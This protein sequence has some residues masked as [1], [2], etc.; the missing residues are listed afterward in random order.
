[1]S[2]QHRTTDTDRQDAYPTTE[3]TE[4]FMN[5]TFA[6]TLLAG[7]VLCSPVFAQN[8]LRPGRLPDGPA[9]AIGSD[10]ETRPTETKPAAPAKAAPTKPSNTDNAK[11]ARL[12]LHQA[13]QLSQTGKTIEECTEI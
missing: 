12:L 4:G 1:L 7:V 5:K 10:V 2:Q 13:A 11:E 8:E 9:K 3:S 6:I